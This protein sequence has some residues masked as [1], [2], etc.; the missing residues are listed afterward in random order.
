MKLELKITKPNHSKVVMYLTD[1]LSRKNSKKSYSLGGDNQL[2]DYDL[3]YVH[4]TTTEGKTI[5]IEF[6]NLIRVEV[7]DGVHVLAGK[8]YDIFS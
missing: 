7:D 2:P 3:Q 5:K 6:L 8:V 4:L 1:K